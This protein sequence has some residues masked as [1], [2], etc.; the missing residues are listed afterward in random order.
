MNDVN[1]KNS[2]SAVNA[3]GISEISCDFDGG[4]IICLANE[5][6]NNIRLEIR[7]DHQSEFYQWFYF[8]LEGRKGQ[9]CVLTIEN[10]Q[11]AAFE[12]GWEDYN[13]CASYDNQD[14][15][16][17]PTRYENGQLI[18]S[19][20]PTQN[21]VYYAYFT[22]Y[23][24]KRLA[25]YVAKVAQHPDVNTS[26][27]GQTLDGQ[28]LDFITVGALAGTQ[29]GTQ[30]EG[31]KIMWVT[32]RQHPGEIMASWWIEGFLDR[33]LDDNDPVAVELREKC[34]FYI[35]P[36]MNPDGSRRGHLRT[37]ACG[38]NLNREWDVA[39]MERSP[40]VLYVMNEMAKTGVD[41]CIDVHGDEALPY[42]FI[43]GAEG[44][45]AFNDVHA[46]RLESFKQ[47]YK[48]ATPEFQTKI[49]Y[50]AAAPGTGRTVMNTNYVANT[51]DCLAMTLEMPFKDNADLPD[52]RV[53]WSAARSAK[54]GADILEPMLEILAKL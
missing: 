31:K 1:V 53:G 49:G 17:V 11:G 12:G 38:A 36:N 37:N 54:L 42:N 35:V 26:V 29:A 6:A 14:W 41:F 15:F 39:T 48:K 5:A 32:A 43:A 2:A 16:R 18:I 7:A 51:Y 46:D 24:M 22:P 34:I 3:N 23:N 52:A 45:H 47:A 13:A 20:T 44:V 50:E 25:G 27:L 33:L 19:H 21:R 30:A 8:R 4:N 10:A 28:D 9:D 40:E